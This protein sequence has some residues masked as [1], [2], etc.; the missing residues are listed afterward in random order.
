M[1]III[2]NVFRNSKVVVAFTFQQFSLKNWFLLQFFL[3]FFS[4]KLLHH[5]FIHLLILHN[6]YDK[7]F[8]TTKKNWLYSR[9]EL[10]F[11]TLFS[12]LFFIIT[13]YRISFLFED[14]IICMYGIYSHSKSEREVIIRKQQQQQKRYN[15]LRTDDRHRFIVK[16]NSSFIRFFVAVC[17]FFQKIKIFNKISFPHW[18]VR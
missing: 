14:F 13:L 4:H 10:T 2:I 15:L 6:S 5:S 3:F 16:K 8:A 12:L 7:D 11:S 18:M 9:Q 17:L 1:K